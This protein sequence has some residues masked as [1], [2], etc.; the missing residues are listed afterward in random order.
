MLGIPFFT[1]GRVKRLIKFG[2]VGG[3]GVVVNL[4]IFEF[5]YRFMFAAVPGETRV[6]IAN[7]AG[8][9]VSIFTNFVLND[10]WTWGDRE[11]GTLRHWFGR[12]VKY[13]VAAGVAAL[14]QLVVTWAAFRFVF[15]QL[16]LEVPVPRWLLQLW[17]SLPAAVDVSP[18]LSLLTGIA[19]GMVINFLASHLWAFQDVEVEA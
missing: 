6:T 16:G 11:K 5:I 18:T 7:L 4:V 12:M 19:C 8:I 1:R 13:Y 3:S 2:I 14:V 17:G 9:L 10:R 15:K